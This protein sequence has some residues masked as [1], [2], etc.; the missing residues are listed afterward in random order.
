MMMMVIFLFVLFS[1]NGIFLKK[2][3]GNFQNNLNL[4]SMPNQFSEK[5]KEKRESEG[6]GV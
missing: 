5:I 1:G 4:I 3:H 6:V 2:N